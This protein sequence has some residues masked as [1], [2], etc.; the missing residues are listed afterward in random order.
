MKSAAMHFQHVGSGVR[1]ASELAQ[2]CRGAHLI[3]AQLLN[4]ALAHDNHS[5]SR[6]QE[7]QLMGDQDARLGCQQAADGACH[8]LLPHMRIHGRKRIVQQVHVCI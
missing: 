1:P 2:A 7:L 3:A 4:A 6:G 5:V 8:E